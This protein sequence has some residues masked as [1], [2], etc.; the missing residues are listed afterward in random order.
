MFD[1]ELY[2]LELLHSGVA[3]DSN[4]PGRGSGRYGWGTGGRAF[5]HETWYAWYQQRDK[6]KEQGL[7][8]K[9]IAEKM[10]MTTAEYRR[11]V[12]INRELKED[13]Y[14]RYT[15]QWM[16]DPDNPKSRNAIAKELGVSEGTLRAIEKRIEEDNA[17]R[18]S[19]T[20]DALKE[21][22]AET[23]YLIVG[24]GTSAYMGVSKETL[25]ASFQQLEEEGWT[26]QK[27]RVE[28]LG[29]ANGQHTEIQVLCP[30]GTT[31]RELQ[32]E[33]LK[34][35]TPVSAHFEETVT[36][37]KKLYNW[38]YPQSISSDRVMINYGDQTGLAKDG[39]IE[40][41]RGVADLN[42]GDGVHYAQVRIA[43]DG[44]HYLKGMAIYADDLPD[45]VDVRFNTNKNSNVDKMDVLKKMKLDDPNNPFGSALRQTDAQYHYIDEDGNDRLGAINKCR[46]E[47]DWGEW[48]KTLSPQVLSKQPVDLANKQLNIKY[49]QLQ[50][51][52]EEIMKITNPVVK[53][54][55]LLELADKCDAAAVDLKAAAMPSQRT[56]VLFPG[57]TLKENECY[58]PDYPDGQ[59]VVLIRYPHA[60]PFEMPELVNNTKNRE[61]KKLLDKAV[62]AIAVPPSAL[63]QLS[64]ADCDGD[65]VTVIPTDGRTLVTKKAIKELQDFE[66][67]RDYAAYEGMQPVG[68]RKKSKPE[69]MGNDGFDTQMQMGKITNLIADMQIK[70]APQ[71]DVIKAVKH[72]MVVIDAEKHQLNW[73]QSEIDNDIKALRKEY[74]GKTSGGASSLITRAGSQFDVPLRKMWTASSKSINPET[75]EKIYEIQDGTYYTDKNGKEKYKKTT[76]TKGAEWDLKD[77][78]SSSTPDPIEVTYGKFMTK[79]KNLG[80]QCRLS[81]LSAGKMEHSP[82]AAK[83]YAPE[84]ESLTRKLRDAESNSP[85][86]QQAQAIANA[87][88]RVR[89]AENPDL[90]SDKDSQSKLKNTLLTN[91]RLVTGAHKERVYPTDREWEALQAGAMYENTMTRILNN[92]D[93]DRIKE[94][95]LPK[96]T[97]TLSTAQ[98]NRIK[99][100]AAN[101]YNQAE[102][103]DYMGISASTVSTVLAPSAA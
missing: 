73:K 20:T 11:M 78:Y 9:E 40:L 63:A 7:S 74:Q 62:D 29:T 53:K 15:K 37:E 94:L 68:L 32:T 24:G 42:L 57:T 103:A 98:Q 43:V 16:N 14:Y 90:K 26:V 79:C 77:L 97:N 25:K 88:Y 66:P 84:V 67:K 102:I 87:E 85:R 31:P 46:Q 80:N 101:G 13:A 50:N 10:Q 56:K 96:S 3:H 41:R 19:K 4:P 36:G 18:I 95:A 23:P 52:Y 55:Q 64:G 28:Q 21:C 65:T 6:W 47:G 49:E 69:T 39:V 82:Q 93:K 61:C 17:G 99:N 45:G 44:T 22:L 48:S 27:I 89:L 58:L 5:Q 71:E 70:G 76:S 51:Q 100:L 2:V 60:G 54:N 12:S 83:T 1:N 81:W 91:A 34:D 38:E 86:E 33:H 8:D 59:K 30:K 75:G 92:A 72:S 35:L